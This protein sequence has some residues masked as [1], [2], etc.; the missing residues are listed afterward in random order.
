M[1]KA[2][3]KEK[4]LEAIG[5]RKTAIARVRMFPQKKSFTEPILVNDKPYKDYFSL[6]EFQKILESPLEKA[7]LFKKYFLSIKVK[8]GGIRGQAEAAR[9]GLARVL[10]KFDSDFKKVLRQDG[11]LTRDARVVER[12][13][14]GLRKARRAQQW[15]KR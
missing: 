3:K 15:R 8:G 10:V 13:K 4:Y 12:K 6:L 9:L 1:K 14:Y 7:G 5:R 2:E 11:F